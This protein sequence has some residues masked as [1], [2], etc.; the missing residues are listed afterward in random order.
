MN[1]ARR[2]RSNMQTCIFDGQPEGGWDTQ[3]QQCT[4]LRVCRAARPLTPKNTPRYE[5]TNDILSRNH[6][7]LPQK[8]GKLHFCFHSIFPVHLLSC[9]A[10]RYDG[11][12]E[13]FPF[14]KLGLCICLDT[15]L[16]LH[17]QH[18]I[19]LAASQSHV[20]FSLTDLPNPARF[21]PP[22][23][24]PIAICCSAAK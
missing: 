10:S 24:K 1:V 11:D 5:A 8:R 4:H 3:S 6:S 21:L 13:A 23:S 9:I 15:I 18:D 2:E 12:E 14:T 20:P 19:L 7:T 17:I 16:K 22:I